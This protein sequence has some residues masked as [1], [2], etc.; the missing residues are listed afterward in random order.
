MVKSEKFKHKSRSKFLVISIYFDVIIF[1][2]V[3]S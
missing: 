3:I 1:P 2:N